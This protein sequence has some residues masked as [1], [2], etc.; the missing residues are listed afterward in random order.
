MEKNKILNVS[1]F[2][3]YDN[4]IRDYKQDN[5]NQLRDDITPTILG[6]FLRRTEFTEDN[7]FIFAYFSFRQSKF[8]MMEENEFK[9][10]LEDYCKNINL[11]SGKYAYWQLNDGS[12]EKISGKFVGVFILNNDL[13][14]NNDNDAH[15]NNFT[16]MLLNKIRR[17]PWFIDESL[18]KD[19]KDFLRGYFDTGCSYD[20][21]NFMAC[22]Y[23]CKTKQDLFKLHK[24][25]LDMES[26]LFPVYY[27]NFNTRLTK[28]TKDK[29]DQFRI[30]VKYYWKEIGSF[31][32]YKAIVINKASKTF[33]GYSPIFLNGI[34]TFNVELKESSTASAIK[35]QNKFFTNYRNFLQIGYGYRVEKQDSDE[36]MNLYREYFSFDVKDK[37][38]K[39]KK[40]SQKIRYEV[41]NEE[42]DECVC[43]KRRYNI[44]DRSYLQLRKIGKEIQQRYYFELHH[45]ISLCNQNE[46]E[47]NVLD[48]NEN[49]VKLCPTCHRCLTGKSGL[50]EDIYSLLHEMLHN[51]EKVLDFSKSYFNTDDEDKLVDDIYEY[52]H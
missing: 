18:T 29:A 47:N 49:L 3:K 28:E 30:N 25:L 10:E 33:N 32:R 39:T 44:K 26:K 1:D 41:L 45:A 21:S 24:T 43:C 19:R 16:E 8:Y 7:A 40:R 27:G 23:Y 35:Q 20:G 34:Y 12:I 37:I 13:K 9:G 11:H 48:V 17:Q 50:K 22:D 46:L 52:L 42:A 4:L 51:S 2:F 31:S 5:I 6:A 38:E 36:S 15:V 14:L